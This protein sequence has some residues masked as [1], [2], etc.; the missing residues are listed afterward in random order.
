MVGTPSRVK[1]ARPANFLRYRLFWLT[2][3]LALPAKCDLPGY[4]LPD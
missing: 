4:L 3:R 1:A 2:A